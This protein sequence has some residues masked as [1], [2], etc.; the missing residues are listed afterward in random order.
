MKHEVLP[1][2]PSEHDV[3]TPGTTPPPAFAPPDEPNPEE[4]RYAIACAR[5]TL[6]NGKEPDGALDATRSTPRCSRSSPPSTRAP[7]TTRP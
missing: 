4:E 7:R 1:G 3:G 6:T 5:K 2:R